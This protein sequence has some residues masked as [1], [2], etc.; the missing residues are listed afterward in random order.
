MENS[1][2]RKATLN[3]LKQI[4]KLVNGLQ[5]IRFF[6]LPT[7]PNDLPVEKVDVNRFFAG[8]DNVEKHVMGGVYTIE[9]IKKVIQM[10]EIISGSPEKLR[11]EPIISMITLGISPLKVDKLYGEMLVTIARAGIPVA[12]PAEPISGATSPATLAGTLVIQNV[13]SLI[14]VL[15]AQIANPGTPVIYGS[16]ATN[17]DPRDLKYLAGS[18]ES[19]LLSAAGAQLAQFYNLPFYATGGMS[20]AKVIDAQCGYESALTILLCALAGGNLIHDAAG[21][22]DFALSASYEKYVIDNEIIGMAMRAVKG[23]EVDE[24]KLAFD[25]IKQ[26]GP[27]GNFLSSKHTRRYVRSEP[28]YPTLS[29]RSSWNEWEGEGKKDICRRAKEKVSEILSNQDFHL[30]P[31]VRSKILAEIPEIVD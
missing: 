11:Q 28:Y 27:G 31:D 26:V 10:A 19:G 18:I 12:Y 2:R 17:A 23:I 14:G 9:G 13:D 21:L 29:D 25:V 15:L 24:D 8:L 22:L 20:D 7:Y 4:A 30:P 5:N 16:V 3:D 1:S 6:L